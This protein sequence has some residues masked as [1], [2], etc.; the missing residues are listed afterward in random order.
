MARTHDIL[1][2]LFRVAINCFLFSFAVKVRT[3]SGL[4]A[5]TVLGSGVTKYLSDKSYET[6]KGAAKT[7][8][9][10][11]YSNKEVLSVQSIQRSVY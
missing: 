7:L 10:T 9:D 4:D 6:R 3:M 8:E 11:V 1:F 5:D 2:P